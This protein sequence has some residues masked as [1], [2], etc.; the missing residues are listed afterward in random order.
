M[1]GI[2]ERRLVKWNYCNILTWNNEEDEFK[3]QIVDESSPHPVLWDYKIQ[4]NQGRLWLK[5]KA[6]FI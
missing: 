1:L 6:D 3:C 5:P 2:H 4:S